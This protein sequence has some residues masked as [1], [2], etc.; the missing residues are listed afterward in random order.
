MI[1]ASPLT[2]CSQVVLLAS[3]LLVRNGKGVTHLKTDMGIY[4]ARF[5]VTVI[6]LRRRRV[7]PALPR[8][9]S[10]GGGRI[11]T[12]GAGPPPCLAVLYR[13]GSASPPPRLVHGSLGNGGGAQEPAN[14]QRLMIT[15][16]Q[17]QF[18]IFYSINEFSRDVHTFKF[19]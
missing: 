4:F 9:S 1:T 3:S 17:F 16:I 2:G 12:R 15:E 10:K 6:T 11:S 18:D 19:T 7:H 5:Q 13:R 14:F 8:N